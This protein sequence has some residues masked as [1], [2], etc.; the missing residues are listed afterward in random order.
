MT[1]SLTKGIITWISAFPFKGGSKNL[2]SPAEVVLGKVKPEYNNKRI[3]FGEY[4]LV[5]TVNTNTTK[6]GASLT[7]LSKNTMIMEDTTLCPYTQLNV[8]IS[9]NGKNP[10]LMMS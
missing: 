3:A 4:A 9:D 6:T 2:M 8:S 7:L 5:Y 10:P 1:G